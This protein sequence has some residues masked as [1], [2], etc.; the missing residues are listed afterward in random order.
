MGLFGKKKKKKVSESDYQWLTVDEALELSEGKDRDSSAPNPKAVAKDLKEQLQNAK[1]IEKD[2]SFEYDAISKHLSDMQR[3]EDLPEKKK[4][5]IKDL[6]ANLLSYEKQRLEYQ[7]GNRLISDEKYR[8]MEMYSSEIPE[9]LK[10]ME[11]QEGYLMLVKNDMRQ[12]EGEKG[13]INFEKDEAVKKKQFLIKFTKLCVVAIL[14]VCIL[15]VVLSVYTGKNM[16]LPIMVT[17]A[18]SCVYAAY[19]VVTMRE[20][21]KTVRR[22]ERLMKR[23]VE[24]LNKV[25]IKYVNTTNTLEYTY[26]KYKCNSHQELR[27]IWEGYLKEKEEEK[28]YI[29][30]SGLLAACRENL[31]DILT[32][33]GFELPEAWTYQAEVFYDGKTFRELRSV[34]TERHRKLKAQLDFNAKQKASIESDINSFSTKYK[35]YF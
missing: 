1:K 14:A 33:C 12:L 8:T 5:K 4:T 2:T 27:F 17:V 19:F 11:E 21:D 28:K 16:L 25:K 18:L 34:M 32:E 35:G 15:F 3:F 31:V 20:C 29:K 13:S 30:N 6:S 9:K 24:L 23:C 7:H 10:T 22:D 26:E